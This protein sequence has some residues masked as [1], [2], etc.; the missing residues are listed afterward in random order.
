MVRPD[1]SAISIETRFFNNINIITCIAYTASTVTYIHRYPKFCWIL[2][3]RWHHRRCKP[4]IFK[5]DVYGVPT[6]SLCAVCTTPPATTYLLTACQFPSHIYVTKVSSA[7]LNCV[8]AWYSSR[9]RN[10]HS[11]KMML[12]ILI[13]SAILHALALS[14][15]W[16]PGE[17]F[18]K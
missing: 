2:T 17:L 6:L 18:I 13:F 4:K 16:Q 5:L 10:L 15:T 3:Q 8:R 9:K 11:I 14:F 1:R 12:E 7:F